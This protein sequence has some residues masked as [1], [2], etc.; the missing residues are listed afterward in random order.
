MKEETHPEWYPE[1]EVVHDGEVVMTVGST[2][3]RLVVDVWSGTHP[4]YTG[5]N[6]ILDTEGQVERFMRRLE[7]QQEMAAAKEKEAP[8]KKDPRTM[9]IGIVG[10]DKRAEN[11]L[12]EA[13]FSTVGDLLA[14]VEE[15]E[16][17][18]LAVQGVG[19]TALIN[20][21]KHLRIEELIE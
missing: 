7:T 10:L 4:F 18:I 19:Q 21:R 13:G 5:K 3:P 2:Q 12:V 11:A 8:V 16:D 20:I 17:K 1:A 6:V 9:E 15:D 14:A